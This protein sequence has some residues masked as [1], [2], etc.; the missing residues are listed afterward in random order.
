LAPVRALRSVEIRVLTERPN[1]TDGGM[2]SAPYQPRHIRRESPLA[3]QLPAINSLQAVYR[4]DQWSAQPTP[5]KLKNHAT[6]GSLDI[7]GDAAWEIGL[8]YA[9]FLAVRNPDYVTTDLVFGG[10][11]AGTIVSLFRPIGNGVIFSNG[12]PG[13][14]SP[15]LFLSASGAIVNYGMTNGSGPY[16]VATTGTVASAPNFIAVSWGDV[17]LSSLIN[18]EEHVHTSAGAVGPIAAGTEPLLLAANET[19]PAGSVGWYWLGVWSEQLPFSA[20]HALQ[21]QMASFLA[22]TP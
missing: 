12:D 21:T 20:L 2:I 16:S 8:N 10:Q 11:A 19:G 5:A 9:P 18:G 1:G 7:T 22:K 13:G 4:F 15:T 6:G 14:A 3:W 17:P